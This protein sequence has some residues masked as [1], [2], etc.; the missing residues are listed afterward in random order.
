MSYDQV[1][2]AS[3]KMS[4]REGNII[5]FSALQESLH[6]EIKTSF[7]EEKQL[8]KDLTEKNTILVINYGKLKTDK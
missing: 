3:G 4:N 8:T 7:L 2:L 5:P 1:V 6:S